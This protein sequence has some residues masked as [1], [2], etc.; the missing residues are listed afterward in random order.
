MMLSG[1]QKEAVEK[2]HKSIATLRNR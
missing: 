1:P 2:S